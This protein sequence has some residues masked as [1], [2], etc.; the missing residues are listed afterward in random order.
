MNETSKKW[1][2]RREGFWRAHHE[3]WKR[4]TLNQRE[5]CAIHDIPLKAF[6]N[7]RAVF[8]AEPKPKAAKL[9]YR[10]G[11]LSHRL[12]H[13]LSHSFS[14]M[15]EEPETSDLC[16]L[17]MR[18]GCRRKFNA[19]A[20]RKILG[21]ADQFGSNTSEVARRYGIAVR[22]L[23]RWRQELALPAESMFVTVVVGEEQQD[24][25]Q[26]H[27]TEGGAS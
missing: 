22:M 10:R 9:L 8:M 20:K 1:V 25:G 18:E 15:T 13:S 14:H 23:F 27:A 21:E 11:D 16:V 17:P 3:T 6:G 12:S 5:Y 4:S 24:Y 7:W 2:R 19:E 26:P